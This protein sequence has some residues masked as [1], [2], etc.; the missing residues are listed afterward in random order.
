MPVRWLLT[1]Q[2]ALAALDEPIPD[3]GLADWDL[4][5]EPAGRPGAAVGA[6]HHAT[7]TTP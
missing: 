7:G 4:V 2:A 1:H 5:V 3:G 6:G